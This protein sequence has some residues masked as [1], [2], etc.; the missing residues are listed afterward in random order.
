MLARVEAPYSEYLK[1]LS[2]EGRGFRRR[3]LDRNL[4]QVAAEFVDAGELRV[5][6]E[7]EAG[8]APDEV[9]EPPAT[10]AEALQ[11]FIRS[12]QED[13][14]G[15]DRRC[16]LYP[17]NIGDLLGEV[18]RAKIRVGG[19]PQPGSV[20]EHSRPWSGEKAHLRRQLTRLL[21]AIVKVNG[22]LRIEEQHRFAEG[23]PVLRTAEAEDVDPTLPSEFR[24]R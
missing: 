12:Q 5:P 23:H 17:W 2:Q 7:H 8:S 20:L 11:Y 19:I 16:D 14:I 3:D 21:A 1:S 4:A 13:G 6:G 15:I 9:V 18:A 22:E 24:W 10:L